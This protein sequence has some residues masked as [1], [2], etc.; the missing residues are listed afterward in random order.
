[1]AVSRKLRLQRIFVSA[2]L[3]LALLVFTGACYQALAFR[4]DTQRSPRPGRLVDVGKFKLNLYCT[5]QGSSTVVLESGLGDALDS[6]IRVQPEIARFARVCSYD[7]AGY[8]YSEPGPMPRT[9]DRIAGELH[10]AL[11]AA[12]E[13]PPFL[14]VGHSFGGYNVRVFNGK[15]SDEVAGLVLVDATQED[16]YR[17]LPRAWAEMGAGV[18][19]R[20]TRQGFWAP[21]YI[22]LGVAR[23]QTRLKG[24]QVPPL[25]LQSK[26][27][28][29][30]ASELLNIE[31]SAE[32]ARAAG[33]IGNKPLVVLTAGRPVDSSL[34]A[35]LSERDCDMYRETWMNDL[36]IRLMRLSARG[37]RVIVPDSG[38]DVPTDRPDAIVSAVRELCVLLNQR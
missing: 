36:Q 14:L 10:A 29:A 25:L 12:G 13:K 18:R 28:K 24:Q 37:R 1:M 21:I 22:D 9:S 7:R 27:I 33:H 23:L 16:Q 11:G 34:K 19:Q 4:V 15:Y 38:H 8:G 30:R 3:F 6:W 31:V 17:L 32:Q 2:L 35:V 5:G 20:A 26:Y